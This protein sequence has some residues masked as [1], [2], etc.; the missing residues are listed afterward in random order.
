MR[1][2]RKVLV[3]PARIAEGLPRKG[4]KSKGGETTR[5]TV[6]EGEDGE[7]DDVIV[8]ILDE[9]PEAETNVRGLEAPGA[10]HT[11]VPTDGP[12]IRLHNVT[13][14]ASPGSTLTKSYR[15]LAE[16]P[17]GDG[18]HHDDGKDVPAWAASGH[19]ENDSSSSVGNGYP[20]RIPMA[21]RL[22]PVIVKRTVPRQLLLAADDIASARRTLR[23]LTFHADLDL[24]LSGVVAEVTSAVS[25]AGD[26][27][28]EAHS[29]E[30]VRSNLARAGMLG[31][32]V[33]VPE[34]VSCPELGPLARCGLLVTTALRGVDVSDA[35]VMEHAAARGEK[36]RTR[37]VDGVFAVFGQM[38]LADGY[39]PSNPMPDNL[40]YM[41][42]GQ[43]G[44]CTGM[45]VTRIPGRGAEPISTV[46]FMSV[47]ARRR[48]SACGED[49]AVV[50][51]SAVSPRSFHGHPCLQ[52]MLAPADFATPHLPHT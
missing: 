29:I 31:T 47:G 51:R 35:Y 26:L 30:R 22:Q 17:F 33:G 14:V 42:S 2:G 49:R 36:E 40:L 34:V 20:P 28:L 12:L 38:C 52:P 32:A 43:V 39:F 7:E 11:G 37:F 45:S 13:A 4:G 8:E 21:S 5:L 6:L 1:L 24:D 18:R 23:R 9:V 44:E 41:Y 25:R 46:F 19:I 10:W 50:L 27:R 48:S 16:L 3:S 15:A